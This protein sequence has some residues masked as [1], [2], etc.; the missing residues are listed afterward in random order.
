M[1]TDDLIAIL[2]TNVEA[3]DR[4]QMT[5]TIRNALLIAGAAVVIAVLVALG[6]RD[7]TTTT[8]TAGALALK[9]G[10]TLIVLALACR[11]LFKLARPGGE[12]EVS[13]AW[14][15]I[16]FVGIIALAGLSLGSASHTH[17]HH[18]LLGDQW[19]E[20]IVS[21]PVIAITPF[22]VLVFAVRQMAPTDLRRTGAIVGLVA[23]SLS[24]AGYALHC[25]DDSVSFVALWYGGTIALCTLVGWA[26]GP[27]LL[28][29]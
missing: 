23:G 27:K 18:V 8:A 25:V 7:D 20:C 12:R 4:R 10:A 1:K 6:V 14:L 3:V 28:R 13:L 26:L 21:I 11:Y 17:W 5:H 15:V 22:A 2:S 24:A 29:W 19:L 16:P 9:L